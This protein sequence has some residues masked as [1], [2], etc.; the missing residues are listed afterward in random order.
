MNKKKILVPLFATCVL[1]AMA[2]TAGSI[3]G[4]VVDQWNKPISGAVVMDAND[5]LNAVP[6][7]KDGSFTISGSKTLKVQAPNRSEKVVEAGDGKVVVKMD[8]ASRPVYTGTG[9]VLTEKESTASVAGAWGSDLNHRSTKD[10]GQ[11]LFG[12]VL[13]LQTLQQ[14]ARFAGV[15]TTNYVRGLQSTNS[16]PLI[17]VDGIEREITDITPEEVD[18]V[19][20]LKDA[21]AAAL[22][23]YKGANGVLVITTKRGLYDKREISASYDHSFN[24]QAR[25]P[26]F[27]DGFTYA[28]AVNEA[29]ANEGATAVYDENALNAYKNGTLPYNFPNVDWVGETMRDVSS[30]DNFNLTFRGG[31][32]KFRYYTLFNLINSNGY[33]KQPN[34]NDGYSTQEKYMKANIRS[35]WDIDL[36]PKTKLAVNLLGTL[37]ESNYP[38][39]NANIWNAIYSMP[40]GAVPVK[41]E[42]GLWGGSSQ[43]AG[44]LNPVALATGA[45][46]SK[47]HRR[48]F[49]A[50]LT[51]TQNLDAFLDGLYG[52]FR[53]AYDNTSLITEN[54]SKLYNYGMNTVTGWNAD[55]TVA[56]V[57]KYKQTVTSESMAENSDLTSY[58]RLFNFYAQLA[59]DKTFGK[60]S[61]YAQGRWEYEYKNYQGLNT[62]NYRMTA[63]LFT[64]YGFLSRYF[65]DT[66]WVYAGSNKLAP[67]HKWTLSPTFSAAWVVSD[68]AWAKD[69]GWLDFLKVRASYG[70]QNTDAIPY[71]DYWEQLY[72]YSGVGYRVGSEFGL[73]NARYE[74]SRLASQA[75]LHERA[76]KFNIGL[77]ATLFGGLDVTMDFFSQQRNNIW[78]E[79]SGK[80]T[81]VLGV[82]APY[83]AAEKI[84]SHGFEL[85]LNYIKN[86]T[87]DL[88][89]NV[90]GNF[91]Y[92]K[93]KVKEM[94]EEPRAFENLVMTGK[95]YGQLTGLQAI[96][97]FKDEA[98]IAAS[99]R[100]NFGPVYPGDIKYKDV[101]GDNVIDAND[102]TSIGYNTLCPE[103]YY[104]FKLGADY[105]NFGF[106]AL[107]QG[108]GNFSAMMSSSLVRPSAS[109]NSISTE[110]Y[111]NRW[112]PENPT[113]K[114]P[115]LSYESSS[116]N[117]RNSSFWLVDRS[118]LKLR[119]VE[120]YYNLPQSVL[121][122][123]KFI[124]KAKVYV[125]GIDL[126]CFDKVKVADPET[127]NT[128]Y[129]TSRSIVAGL[130]LDF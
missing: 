121:N 51:L 87:S 26:K 116:N 102:V 89:V 40:S 94:L 54:R 38:G 69:L 130:S 128:L 22:Y 129:P 30:T 65:F 110:Y 123:I 23:G 75:S 10:I 31:G 43:F 39:D 7:R 88:T 124:S 2:Q 67:G 104:S 72:K 33:I 62:T 111:N 47:N 106:T 80:Y 100:Q 17:I 46:Y 105:K 15:S 29:R 52:S 125:R 8:Y 81:A 118:F 24:W 56:S 50:D 93:N 114:Y 86:V 63:S 3:T 59:Y 82:E 58:N 117:N 126:L 79:A 78:V 19:S 73:G 98:D 61:I 76:D 107:F 85:G 127:P 32:M 35:N 92:N 42:D 66:S 11:S 45:A 34:L 60:H 36:S 112:T 71:E 25:R 55:G 91:T 5:P 48:T 13:G 77:D 74:M 103:I 21:A 68:E 64:H 109:G 97:L 4:V 41:T 113:A 27:V 95:P 99:P 57:N 14:S 83:E 49:D 115:R 122:R 84:S 28:G 96:G 70:V 108:A 12:Q 53:L 20:V 1:Q 120:A 6:T 37:A 18:H 9:K 44:T 16:S 119:Y 90:G 101:N